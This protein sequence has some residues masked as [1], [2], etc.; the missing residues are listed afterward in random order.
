VASF[1]DLSILDG[2]AIGE[3]V[4]RVFESKGVK[5]DVWVDGWGKGCR[6]V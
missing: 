2:K 5:V 3:A 1:F 6:R 4:R